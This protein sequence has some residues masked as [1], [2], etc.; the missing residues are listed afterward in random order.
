MAGA[1]LLLDDD[2]D[3]LES[4]ADV[5]RNLCLREC[6]TVSSVRELVALGEKVHGCGTAVLDIN[7]GAGRP[8]GVDAYN[9]LREMQFAGKIFFLTGHAHSHPL[10]QEARH[11][12]NVQIIEK[13]AVVD[14]LRAVFTS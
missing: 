13:P 3:M 5:A 2:A 7:L 6:V 1:V 8:S 14:V 11:L 9:W 10:V 12:G 4:L